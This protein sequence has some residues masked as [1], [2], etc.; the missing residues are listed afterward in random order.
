MSDELPIG[1]EL[2]TDVLALNL[3]IIDTKVAEFSGETN[4]TIT[5]EDDPEVLSSCAWGFIFAAG[6][7][8]FA[9]ARPR[10]ASDMDYAEDDQWTV[11]D[12]LRHLRFER[13]RV[14][15][16]ADYIRGRCIKTSIEIDTEGRIVLRTVNRGEAATRWVAKLQGKKLLALVEDEADD[17]GRD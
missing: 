14:N 7:L 1:Y 15:F 16:H 3:K 11:D 8:S 6:V 4:V 10:G 12:M 2:L 17:P 5:L 9:D 13:G